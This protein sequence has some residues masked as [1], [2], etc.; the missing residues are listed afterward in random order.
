MY[1]QAESVYGLYDIEP[2]SPTTKLERPQM[3]AK[4][5]IPHIF[6]FQSIRICWEY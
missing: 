4:F 3:T 2:I 1:K 5:L 6:E